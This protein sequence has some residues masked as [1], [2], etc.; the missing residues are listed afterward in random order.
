[1]VMA[2]LSWAQSEDQGSV[3]GRVLDESSGFGVSGASVVVLETGADTTTDLRGGYSIRGIAAGTVTLV[4]TKEGF[5][6]TTI[7]GDE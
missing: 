6:P 2:P 5:E 7:T 3:S 1:M 4:L